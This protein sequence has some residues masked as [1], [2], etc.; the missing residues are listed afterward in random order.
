MTPLKYECGVKI[1]T[2]TFIRSKICLSD[3][4]MD[5]ALVTPTQTH[6][7]PFMQCIPLNPTDENTV[8]QN[9]VIIGNDLLSIQCQDINS[10]A[11]GKF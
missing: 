1:L 7:W 11:P 5:I 2:G 8:L 9:L 4:L 6:F 3:K 10:L